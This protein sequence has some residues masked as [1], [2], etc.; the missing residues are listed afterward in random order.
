M[1]EALGQWSQTYLKPFHTEIVN[2]VR[3]DLGVEAQGAQ[4]RQT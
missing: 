3:G 1:L 4:S 2:T